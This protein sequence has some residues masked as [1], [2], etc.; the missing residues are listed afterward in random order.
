MFVF[1]FPPN[2]QFKETLSNYQELCVL[3]HEYL[4]NGLLF[5]Q[6][7]HCQISVV[8]NL[9]NSKAIRVFL[10]KDL[11]LSNVQVFIESPQSH[12][13]LSVNLFCEL[14]LLSYDFEEKEK[15]EGKNCIF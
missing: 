15:I 1:F 8:P 5:W 11:P 7:F 10:E 13:M 9:S 4:E 14:F 6:L 2:T 12:N 3:C